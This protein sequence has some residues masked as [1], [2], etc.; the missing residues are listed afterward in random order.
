VVRDRGSAGPRYMRATLNQVPFSADL[1]NNSAM[2]LAVCISPLALPDPNDDQI[3]VVDFGDMGPVRCSRCKAY[4]N[5]F[6]RFM[7]SGRTF[8]CNFCGHSNQTPE[9]YFCHL[10]PD[11]R[12]RDA[13]ERPELCRG[14]V[15]FVATQDFMV[16]PPM[17]PVHFFVIDVTAA[18]VSSGVT[19]TICDCISRVLDDIPGPERTMVGIATFDSTIHF[20]SV[21]P[22]SS[23]PQMLVVPDV[24]E[25]YVPDSAPLILNLEQNKEALQA[26]LG[27]IPSM[28]SQGARS[29]DSCGGAAVEAGI[30]ALQPSGGKVH[31]FVCSLPSVGLHA[32]KNRDAGAVNDK[33]KMAFLSSQ[34][35]TLKSLATV[36][37][38]FQVSV[39]ISF[40]SQGYV[41]IATFSDI[42]S[43]TGG[44]I[45]QYTP[46]NPVL[47]HDQV[48]ND[49]KWNVVRPQGLE[50]VMRL[51]CSQG[52]EVDHYL[53]AFYR[54]L[55]NVTDVYLP[56][57]DCDKSILATVRHVEK[58]SAGAECYLQAALLYTTT[59]GQ[60]RI[61]VH[62][63]ALPIT[64]NI[65]TVFKGADLDAQIS[66]ISRRL[67]ASLPGTTLG[68]A[69]ESITSNTVA[70]LAAYRKYCAAN[71]SAVQ[72][73]LPEALKLLPLYAL[74]LLKGPALKDGAKPDERS[75]WMSHMMSLPAARITPLLYPRLLP[76]LKILEGQE[77]VEGLS[78]GVVLS[79]E[80][81]E[82][83]GAY[84]LEN[85][86]EALLHLDKMASP[87]L[88]LELF[89]VS[90]DDLLRNPHP[91]AL[92]PRDTPASQR[93]QDLLVKV[94]VHRSSFLRLRVTRKGDAHEAAF[95]NMLVE[96]RSTAGMSY[97][98]Y[99]CQVH[100]L[101]QLK[102]Q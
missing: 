70:T 82:T 19:Q 85:G 77:E 61:R 34:D 11:G 86:M 63:L 36:A 95:F 49:L 56:A 71:S 52:L 37:A 53:G 99:L 29:S 74:S 69:R 65:S 13:D 6:M 3:Q 50:A 54:Q 39:D 20:Y 89:G 21:R 96:D 57:I 45:Y 32:L 58:L 68:A 76:L 28:F 18:A 73:I 66:T 101:I 40:L 41:D 48:L 94:R 14:S 2:P 83:G 67:A 4:M 64:D 55:A 88:F 10:G 84:L 72:L 16:R 75:L 42:T 7:S 26:L 30:L 1:L 27:Q 62:T 5:P 97:V 15:E 47:D 51:R 98:E 25:L 31:A 60:R 81:M 91:V 24:T 87:Q 80:V 46:F 33:E 17:P 38:D 93:L 90:L 23:Q 44:T 9:A 22:G 102:L 100:R 12:R 43:S 79:S 35:N 78:D 59:D 8:V 92:V